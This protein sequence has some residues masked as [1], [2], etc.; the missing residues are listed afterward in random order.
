MSAAEPADPTPPAVNISVDAHVIDISKRFAGR[1]GTTDKGRWT[2]MSDP[3]TPRSLR[4]IQPE[5]NVAQQFADDIEAGFNGLG[6][7]LTD[8]DTLLVYLHTLGLTD[9]LLSGAAAQGIIDEGQRAKLA[10][11][12][13]GF[14]ELPAHLQH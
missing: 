10:D 12:I 7:T 8:E 4:G 9:R 13:D 14:K 3:T 11:M 2:G 5:R 6:R 1:A